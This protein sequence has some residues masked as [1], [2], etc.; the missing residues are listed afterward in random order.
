LA[1]RKPGLAF[2]EESILLSEKV[3][4]LKSRARRRF[5][6]EPMGRLKKTK[7]Q[8]KHSVKENQFL[9][10]LRSFMLV[11]SSSGSC[12]DAAAVTANV[13]PDWLLKMPLQKKLWQ[14]YCKPVTKIY[15]NLRTLSPRCHLTIASPRTKAKTI[16]KQTCC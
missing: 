3:S 1:I 13:S 15:Q 10:E 9:A 5:Q 7:S 2:P 6:P 4:L 11:H 12:G 16:L 8:A 14:P